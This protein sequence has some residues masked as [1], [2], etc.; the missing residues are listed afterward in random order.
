M[1]IRWDPDKARTNLAK[2]GIAF[3]DAEVALTGPNGMTREDPDTRG[4]RRFVTVGA[5]ALGRI[6]TIV[7]TYRGDRVRLISACPATRRETDLH[8]QGI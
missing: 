4:E 6:A 7:Y 1:D 3:E 2:R 5:D 8:A